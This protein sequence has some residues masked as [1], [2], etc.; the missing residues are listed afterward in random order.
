[1]EGKV[2][3]DALKKN[4]MAQNWIQPGAKIKNSYEK[5]KISSI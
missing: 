2:I 1:M 3:Q 4:D 5:K